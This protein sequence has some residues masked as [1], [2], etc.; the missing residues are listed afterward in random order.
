MVFDVLTKRHGNSVTML[1]QLQD[2][3]VSIVDEDRELAMR[4]MYRETHKLNLRPHQLVSK[5]KLGNMTDE[6]QC[7]GGGAPRVGAPRVGPSFFSSLSVEFAQAF[8][9]TRQT[10]TS[11]RPSVS[12]TKFHEKSEREEKRSS[13]KSEILGGSGKGG[14]LGRLVLGR[15]AFGYLGI[16]FEPTYTFGKSR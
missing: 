9:T 15:V 2:G 16:N 3:V 14:C 8:T 7:Q 4:K 13:K 6:V 1:R 11:E 12:N 10:C 5:R